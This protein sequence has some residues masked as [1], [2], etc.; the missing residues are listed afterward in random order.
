[1][2]FVSTLLVNLSIFVCSWLLFGLV[3]WIIGLAH[4]DFAENP[5]DRPDKVCVSNVDHNAPFTSAFLFSLETQTTIGMYK[6]YY[7]EKTKGE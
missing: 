6:S 1:M 7:S 2:S 5:A 3:Y 4:G